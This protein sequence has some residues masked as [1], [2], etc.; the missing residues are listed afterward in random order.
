LGPVFADA[1]VAKI[2]HNLKFDLRVLTRAGMETNGPQFDTML[3]AQLLEPDMECGLKELA[4]RE[5]GVMMTD[6]RALTTRGK[7]RL[8]LLQWWSCAVAAYAGADAEATYRLYERFVDRVSAEGLQPV[9]DLEM[10]LL[11][12]VARMEDAGV[13]I[14]VPYLHGLEKMM[15]ADVARI[16]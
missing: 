5:L 16:A 1:S 7:R 3:A 4:R 8:G 6:Y 13:R 10:A 2:G 9:F 14:D 12:I 11:P 15:T